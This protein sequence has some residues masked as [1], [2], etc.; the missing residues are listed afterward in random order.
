MP[1]AQGIAKQLKAVKQT[2]LGAPGSTGSALVRRLTA[3]FNLDRDTYSSNE[4]A[5]HQ[6]STGA[7]A[8]IGKTSGKL[9]CE[10]SPGTYAN[11]WAALLRKDMAA[12]AAMT[13]VGITISGGAPA[14]TVQRSAGSW[15]TD[16]VKAGDVVRLSVGALNGANISK[17][18]IV[19]AI[20]SGTAMTVVPLNG[21]ALM[22]EGPI[23]G[24]TVTVVGKKTRVPTSGHTNDYFSVE[25]WFAD[26]VKSELYTD[27]KV[28]MADVALPATG[29]ATVNFDMPGLG[30]TTGA[31]EVMTSPTP[32][33][34]T[35][36]LSAV[37]GKVI[38]G[39]AV[40]SV[41][42]AQ[43][44]ITGNIQAG[45]AEMG[46]NAI[47]DHQRGRVAVTGSFTAKFSSTTLQDLFNS[48]APAHLILVAAANSM[49][50]SDFVAFSLSNVKILSDGADDGEKEIIRT[51]S[52]TAAIN[53]AGGTALAN[54]QTIISIQDSA[55]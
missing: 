43:L 38:I 12:T 44:Q 6:Q 46:S 37:A 34:G 45:E 14:W 36:I 29:I 31:A 35:S 4:I 51:Y 2:A 10:I 5:S 49:P 23:T 22:S 20:S 30:R 15:L 41:T 33:T 13:A 52:F 54:D 32:E 21:V 16:G 3:T 28:A 18:L 48:Q 24:C 47:S 42:G 11:F 1:V 26:L 50:A 9:N 19:T 27:V 39:G 40:T 8:G 53:G 17:N 55:A 25:Q 7:T